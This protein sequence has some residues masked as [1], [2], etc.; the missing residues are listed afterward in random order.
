MYAEELKFF[1]NRFGPEE[2]SRLADFAV[3]LTTSSKT[4]LQDVLETTHILRRLEKVLVLLKK[5]VEVAKA[6]MRIHKQVE[7]SIQTHQREVLLREQ[8]KAIQRELGI[9]KDDRTAELERFRARI[10]DSDLPAEARKRIDEEMQKMSVLEIGSPE[11]AVTRNYLDWLTLMP[12]GKH[13]QDN[14]DLDHA[15]ALLDRDHD[16]LDDVKD[17]IIE[18]LG[19]GAMK[20]EVAGSIMLLVGPPGCG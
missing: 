4:E 14:L 13:S 10:K 20:G 7:E 18:F 12:W 2:P 9:A 3:S 15:H 8:L 19:V 16:G 17:R 6:Q 1:L 11:Y 5:E